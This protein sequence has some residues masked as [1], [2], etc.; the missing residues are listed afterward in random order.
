MSMV[1]ELPEDIQQRMIEKLLGKVNAERI[2]TATKNFRPTP[3]VVSYEFYQL[4]VQEFRSWR[5][6]RIENGR[7]E[8]HL[9]NV[10]WARCRQ[11]IDA[12]RAKGLTV[13]QVAIGLQP[14]KAQREQARNAGK[15]RRATIMDK[16]KDIKI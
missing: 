4:P 14:T 16:L 9:V 11:E 1:E 8:Q 12:L 13:K 3:V 5:I 15:A 2:K 7:K 6:D 10:D